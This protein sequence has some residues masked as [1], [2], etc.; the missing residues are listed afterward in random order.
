MASKPTFK[1]IERD[2]TLEVN[3]D[4]QFDIQES[5][6]SATKA[7]LYAKKEVDPQFKDT[8]EEMWH[9]KSSV[10]NSG[11][12]IIEINDKTK[13]IGLQRI[14]VEYEAPEEDITVYYHPTVKDDKV[15]VFNEQL[16][17]V[18]VDESKL[19]VKFNSNSTPDNVLSERETEA[20]L[21]EYNEEIKGVIKD[22]SLK[23]TPPTD[24]IYNAERFKGPT[25]NSISY[26]MLAENPKS[27]AKR[28]MM[29]M[30]VSNS[31]LAYSSG[32]KPENTT[33]ASKPKADWL[34]PPNPRD[35]FTKKIDL[36]KEKRLEVRGEEFNTD[37]DFEAKAEVYGINDTSDSAFPK[38]F[39][40][41][42]LSDAMRSVA[43]PFSEDEQRLMVVTDNWNEP[44]LS[45]V[46]VAT[47]IARF[48]IYD[49][50]NASETSNTN[51][52]A[53]LVE[54][55]DEFT[56]ILQKATRIDNP[57][58]INAIHNTI[59][60]LYEQY[61]VQDL[62]EME[63]FDAIEPYLEKNRGKYSPKQYEE[64]VDN[65]INE[66][67]SEIGEERTEH[68]QQKLEQFKEEYFDN[69]YKVTNTD[70]LDDLDIDGANMDIDNILSAIEKDMAG[71]SIAIADNTV[72]NTKQAN[73]EL[74]NTASNS[75][76]PR[77]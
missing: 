36:A 40:Q 74:D 49:S 33:D 19:N 14:A 27:L 43:P 13:D 53:D 76:S 51:P 25:A 75:P 5:N 24:K 18:D 22:F 4:E 56:G 47:R 11:S 28:E 69:K 57:K 20:L 60:E 17:L 30:V 77:P 8:P 42:K 31:E 62:V 55:A 29:W 52:Y 71:E 73:N 16:E 58:H 12:V 50:F 54:R 72:G 41:Q 23:R 9:T 48:T 35:L 68:W 2:G 7:M 34:L 1:R 26:K 6:R 59:T 66:K 15:V 39:I 37:A 45:E 46:G 65:A 10:V 67:L 44:T 63:V 21:Q 38:N 64:I 70:N 61:I 32:N 3:I